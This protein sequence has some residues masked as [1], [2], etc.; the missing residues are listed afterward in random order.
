VNSVY[1]SH[2]AVTDVSRKTFLFS[3]RS[4]SG[5]FGFAGADEGTLKVWVDRNSLEGGPDRMRIRAADEKKS[6]DLV[7]TPTKPAVFHGDRGYSRKS[8]TSPLA[9]SL[10]FSYT[11]LATGGTLRVG[12]EEF[13]VAGRSWFDQEISSLP[14]PA[15]I[16]GWDWFAL[17][18]DDGREM[19]LC[20]LRNAEGTTDAYSSGTVIGRDGKYRHLKREDF[21]VTET[22]Y[23]RS[24]RTRARY[25]SQW[26]IAVPSEGFSATVTPLVEDQEFVADRT[27]F[28]T[29]WE[30]ACR[31]SGSHTGKAY[32]EM[33][34]YRR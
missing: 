19:M 1:I 8:A 12:G 30:G 6:L 21:S 2:F 7:L 9:A 22:A 17:M 15:G 11:S 24:T 16:E 29:Y 26:V 27:T 34:G 32:V 25:P 18:L 14:L 23:Y 5:A 28:N 10:Y 33:T 3:D 13:A 20:L 4:D 31:I